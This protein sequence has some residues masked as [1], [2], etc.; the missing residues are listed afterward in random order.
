MPT[1]RKTTKMQPTKAPKV[2]KA[3]RDAAQTLTNAVIIEIEAQLAAAERG[4]M[5]IMPWSKPWNNG[6]AMVGMP[7]SLATGKW[8]RGINIFV[9]WLTAMSK[10]YTSDLWA[11]YKQIAERGGQVRKGEKSVEIV[12]WTI[13][14]TTEMVNGKPVEKRIPFLR[15]F[16]VFNIEQADWP[17]GSRKPKTAEPVEATENPDQ[18]ID[19]AMELV[20]DYLADGPSLDHDGGNR[21]FYT[22]KTDGVHMPEFEVFESAE[23]YYSTLYHELTHSTGH[24]SRLKR[25][26]IADG[27]FGPFGSETYSQEEL[28]AEMGAAMMCAIAGINQAATMPASVAYIKHWLGKLRED[29]NLLIRAASQAQKAV[30]R[31]IGTTFDQVEEE[32]ENNEQELVSA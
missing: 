31:M 8:Y 3:P 26:G 32:D 29:K 1:T 2:S 18:P 16:H 23:H 19:H 12:F 11:T 7:R 13:W 6:S 5:V 30:D 28:V 14:K 24:D 22:P 10:G 20:A 15:I 17:E 9:L 27:T 25:D 4:D 21:A